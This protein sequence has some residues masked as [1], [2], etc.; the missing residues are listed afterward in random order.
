MATVRFTPNLR[1]HLDVE[2]AEV[3]GKTL[4]GVLETLFRDNEQLRSYLLD[5]QGG[6]RPHVTI[7]VDNRRVKDRRELGDAV[8]VE[9]EIY[10][11]QALSGGQA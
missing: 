2:L 7:F 9:S 5:D 10:V 8:G 1:R 4:R 6:L 11:M 3:P